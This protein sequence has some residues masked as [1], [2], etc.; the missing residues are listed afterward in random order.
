[1]AHAAVDAEEIPP[2]LFGGDSAEESDLLS[3]YIVN[4]IQPL[5][6]RV[7]VLVGGIFGLYMILILARIHYERKKVKLLKDIRYDLD[8][9][10][11]HYKVP[12]S[13]E[14]NG[15]FKKLWCKAWKKNSLKGSKENKKLKK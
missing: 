8:H 1:M 13:R 2:G 7:S 15:F 14:R 4:T 11:M 3:Q 9:L 6:K 10:N 5:L 12:H